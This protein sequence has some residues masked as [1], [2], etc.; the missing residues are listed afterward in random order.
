MPENELIR[1]EL[2]NLEVEIRRVATIVKTAKYH[3]GIGDIIM[4]YAADVISNT[5]QKQRP[6]KAVSGL[7]NDS[8]K[9]L[10]EGVLLLQSAKELL[11]MLFECT[12]SRQITSFFADICRIET[13]MRLFESSDLVSWDGKPKERSF[14]PLALS[15]ALIMTESFA[16]SPTVIRH[17]ID[18]V[19][20]LESVL[21]EAA[22]DLFSNE[23]T[24]TLCVH[25]SK[26]RLCLPYLPVP[27]EDVGYMETTVKTV[28]RR[29]PKHTFNARRN[30]HLLKLRTSGSAT[31]TALSLSSVRPADIEHKLNTPDLP[32]NTA[33]IL[34]SS[35][36]SALNRGGSHVDSD[37][38]IHNGAPPSSS[39]AKP[40]ADTN[41]RGLV[42]GSVS[43][44][45]VDYSDLSF[46]RH[47]IGRRAGQW[48]RV[49]RGAYADVLSAQ[50]DSRNV[51]VKEWRVS[52]R[53]QKVAHDEFLRCM[54]LLVS[55][56]HPNVAR[57]MGACTSMDDSG[58]PYLSIVMESVQSTLE[59]ILFEEDT[60]IFLDKLK[61]IFTQTAAGMSYLHRFGYHGDLKPSNIGIVVTTN[62]STSTE[63]RRPLSTVTAKVLDFGLLGMRD[64]ISASLEPPL[65]CWS[66]PEVHRA[67]CITGYVL[68]SDVWSW[69]AIMLAGM[70]Q[71]RPA[72]QRPSISKACF[73]E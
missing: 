60:P 33:A 18:V 36:T 20:T 35:S 64:V 49:G 37:K 62:H 52:S 14:R 66:A 53:N 40:D 68:A 15:P 39:D 34:R 4:R 9:V 69:A 29:C 2:A 50:Y 48:V 41:P 38:V 31:N 1:H 11:E 73:P 8:Q 65:S 45:D 57:I 32:S 13:L 28:L 58:V 25:L 6:V 12:I 16:R 19:K 70:T 54:N 61:L 56:C 21:T 55:I 17:G 71:K 23:C 5:R 63:G 26:I 67:N 59:D 7:T 24:A 43:T 72:M 3:A 30:A 44:W 10:A 47:T 22:N 27:Q 46:D 51:A 42:E